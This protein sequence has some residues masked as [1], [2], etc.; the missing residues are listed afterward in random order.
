[1]GQRSSIDR[2]P[3]D[4]RGEVDAA[5]KRGATIDEM[6]GMLLD[7]HDQGK[8][9]GPVSRSAL[10]RYSLQYRDLAARQRDMASVAKAFGS[11]F[12]DADDLQGRLMIQLVTSLIT[13]VAMNASDAE[14]AE[15]K[16]K[17]L[18][19]LARAVKDATSASKTDLDREVKIR[20]EAARKARQVAADAAV[21][22]AKASGASDETI[23]TVR[24]A[25]LGLEL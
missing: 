19:D 9:A 3:P 22:S 17:D 25:I 15:F 14:D 20:E 24:A 18:A 4:I 21:S 2:L 11:E 16:F 8:L 7:L 1:M 23:R 6:V 10:G 13:R 12:G 5:I